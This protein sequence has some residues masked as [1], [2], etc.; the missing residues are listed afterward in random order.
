MKYRRFGKTGLDV[1]IFTL[2]LMRYMSDDADA[3]ARIVHRAVELG[4]NH[5]ET[6]RGYG[7]SEQLLGHALTGLDRDKLVLTT[8]IGPQESYDEFMRSVEDS[9]RRM[10]IDWL[11]NLDI[12]G[13]NNPRKFDLAMNRRGTWRAVARLLDQKVIRH[14]GFS[15]H[16]PLSII[17]QTI[18]TGLFESVNLHYYYFQQTNWP[19]VVRARQRDMGVFIISPND[20]G[21]MLF[22]PPQRLRDLAAPF[23]PMNLAS[24]WLLA[25]PEVHTLSLGAERVGDFDLHMQIAD[26][27]G[28]LSP[29]EAAA[30]GRWDANWRRALGADYCTVCGRCL[31]CPER[32]DIPNVLRLRNMACAFDMHAYG[33][34][35]YNLLNG[36]DD[37]FQGWTADHCTECGQCLPRCPEK[38]DIPRLLF[39]VHDSLKARPGHRLWG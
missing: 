22:D 30:I 19:A 31:P 10:G 18:D 33:R 4:I 16:G 21:G 3:S 2:G 37:W 35:R 24:R 5:I 14:V 12:H 29:D 26:S 23:E 38:L 15:T 17:L 9:M 20:K 36:S 34:Y 13:I 11:D 25:K 1:S 28:P 6:A 39:D 32:I 27:D 8:K 7:T